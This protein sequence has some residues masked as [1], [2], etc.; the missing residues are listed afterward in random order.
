MSNDQHLQSTEQNLVPNNKITLRFFELTDAE[1]RND[2]LQAIAEHYDITTD[3]A[4]AEITDDE[5]E[6]L[7]DYLIGPVRTAA[8]VLMQR[9]GL[10]SF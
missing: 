8:Y 4:L 9:H 6:H 5:A 2:I 3:E 7:L 10:V 1:T